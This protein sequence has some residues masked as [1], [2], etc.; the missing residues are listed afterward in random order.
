MPFVPFKKK[1]KSDK[2]DSKDKKEDKSKAKIDTGPS[3]NLKAK[4]GVK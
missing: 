1:S 4:M 3:K 2:T